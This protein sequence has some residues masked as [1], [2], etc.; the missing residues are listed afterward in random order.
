MFSSAATRCISD[1]MVAFTDTHNIRDRQHLFS[2]LL[3][4]A[5]CSARNIMRYFHTATLQFN[6][7]YSHRTR[8]A[9]ATLVHGPI[10]S[11]NTC[12]ACFGFV[13]KYHSMS[14]GNIAEDFTKA[15]H[16]AE[17]KSKDDDLNFATFKTLET[18]PVSHNMSWRHPDTIAA[19]P[20]SK[21]CNSWNSQLCNSTLRNLYCHRNGIH[22]LYHRYI[23][24]FCKLFLTIPIIITMDYTQKFPITRFGN[25]FR[26]NTN[27]SYSQK[28]VL[29]LHNHGSTRMPYCL[30]PSKCRNFFTAKT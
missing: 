20:N 21:I 1:T 25:S 27:A 17:L 28:F 16:D 15:S 9:I 22:S 3:K 24:H 19:N 29:R 4:R 11:E 10:N 23:Y 12:Q 8:P 18:P 14:S 5:H 7:G 6:L 26:T 13:G 30:L 2:Q